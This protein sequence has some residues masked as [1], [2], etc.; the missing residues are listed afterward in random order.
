MVALAPYTQSI[1]VTSALLAPHQSTQAQQ[2]AAANIPHCTLHTAHR[3]LQ[4]TLH[5]A[6]TT[7]C[8]LHSSQGQNIL[9]LSTVNA[10]QILAAQTCQAVTKAQG[11]SILPSLHSLR[12]SMFI[13]AQMM[14]EHQGK[15][16]S[17][18]S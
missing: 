10:L 3:T 8:K 17:K 14:V 4:A 5:T 18:K 7:H 16:L 13:Q 6:H 11:L 2:K 9:H 15:C 12:I 1:A